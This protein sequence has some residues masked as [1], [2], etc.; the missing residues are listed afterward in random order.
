MRNH[1][2]RGVSMMLALA[3][4]SCAV[5]TLA[6][7]QTLS[8]VNKADSALLIVKLPTCTTACPTSVQGVWRYGSHQFTRTLKPK[9]VDTVR[10]ARLGVADSATF[11]YT[12]IKATQKSVAVAAYVAPAPPVVTPPVITPPATP[13][14]PSGA[15]VLPTLPA[16]LAVPY[17]ATT[18]RVD[19]P[20]GADLQQALNNAQ[21]GDELVLANGA[22]FT[23]NYLLPAK[24]GNGWIVVRCE[25]LATPLGVRATPGG[26]CATIITPNTEPAIRT[27]SGAA[28]WRFVGLQIEHAP[29]A[30]NT[31]QNYGIVVLGAGNETTLAQMPAD[32]VLDRVQVR[33][34]TTVGNSRCVAF[35]GIRQALIDSYVTECHGAGN[36]AQGVGGWNGPG[37]F[38]IENNRIEGSGQNIMFGGADPKIT[39]LSPSDIV[40]RR[41]YLYKPLSWGRGVWTVKAAF[42]LKHA[43]RVLFEGNVI[44]N[45]WADAQVGFAILFTTLADNNTSWAWTTVQDITVRD[46]LIQNSTSGI[47]LSAR[48]VYNNGTLPTN[49]TSRVLVDNNWFENVGRDPFQNAASAAVQLLADLVDVTVT[50]NTFSCACSMQSVVNFDGAPQTRTTITDN[51]FGASSYFVTGNNTGI[52]TATLNAFMPGGVFLR[53][54]I[55]GASASQFPINALGNA[56][57]ADT[58]AIRRATAGVVR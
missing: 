13:L 34:S 8:V 5:A 55:P 24:V 56:A 36:D 27:A 28:R 52:G 53:N 7:A 14:P 1:L 54:T 16:P 40:I 48:S 12:P 41:N 18:R 44:E 29:P 19:V 30:S 21:P 2:R 20:A 25:T 10:V 45:H 46:N 3:L 49:P 9:A 38:L 50:R 11:D 6:P 4:A 47:N 35:N 58:L 39:N 22:A 31:Y 37:P 43:R 51:V 33:G 23:G 57:G 42:E 26:T 17:P 32:I 15:Y